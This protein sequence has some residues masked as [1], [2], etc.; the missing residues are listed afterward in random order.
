MHTEF[1]PIVSRLVHFTDDHGNIT[2]AQIVYG[3]I[4]AETAAVMRLQDTFLS[5]RMRVSDISE[6]LKDKYRK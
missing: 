2:E 5:T 3:S 1:Q 4:N 6:N